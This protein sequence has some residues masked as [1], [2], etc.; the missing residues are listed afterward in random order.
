MKSPVSSEVTA[1]AI[2]GSRKNRNSHAPPGRISRYGAA[3]RAIRTRSAGLRPARGGV[4]VSCKFAT[5]LSDD[6][7]V[8]DVVPLLRLARREDA[9]VRALGQIR[10]ARKDERA[11][12]SA[13]QRVLRRL[14]AR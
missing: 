11:V 12:R 6:H 8:E 14:V 13:V 4:A 7:R 10:G 1:S 5:G 3:A 2:R 9:V